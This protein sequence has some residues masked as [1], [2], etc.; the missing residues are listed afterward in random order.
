MELTNRNFFE[1]LP[2]AYHEWFFDGNSVNLVAMPLFRIA[3]SGWGVVGLY[4][5]GTYVLLRD[6]DP[7]ATLALIP[8]H[9]VT[10]AL[11]LP[12]VLQ[13][14]PLTP[15]IDDADFSTQGDGL[16][17]LADH[18]GGPCGLHAGHGLS[19]DRHPAAG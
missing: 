14:L 1:M 8:R 17:R 9:G 4:N 3:G 5:G 11:L 10:N 13:F 16:R 6:V 2:A 15:N 12:A 18:R 7:A 19:A